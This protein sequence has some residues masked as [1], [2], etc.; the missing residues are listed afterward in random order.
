MQQT[1]EQAT[2]RYENRNRSG[3]IVI[4]GTLLVSMTFSFACYLKGLDILPQGPLFAIAEATKSAWSEGSLTPQYYHDVFESARQ[5]SLSSSNEV[6]QDVFALTDDG[7]LLPKHSIFTVLIGVPFYALF[8]KFGFWILQQLFLLVLVYSTHRQVEIVSGRSM[9]IATV[10]VTCVFTPL[11]LFSFGPVYD[12][13]GTAL[14]VAGIYVGLSRP[15]VGGFIA[16]L[17]VFVRPT[18]ILLSLPLCLIKLRIHG[19]RDIAAS[20]LGLSGAVI[21]YTA[22]NWSWWGEPFLTAYHRLPHFIAG[23]MILRR[24][25]LGFN[26]AIF[27]ADWLNKLF[28]PN[29]AFSFNVALVAAP[30]VLAT[31]LRHKERGFLLSC[32][33]L[34]LLYSLYVFSYPMWS[35]SSMY[36]NRFLL[37]AI[38]IYI[39]SL[40]VAFGMRQGRQ[41][42]PR[43]V[44]QQN[45]AL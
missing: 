19:R 2:P 7:R 14:V 22:L 40:L 38:F 36:G 39:P 42:G 17:A 41:N 30:W 8:G 18:F 29:G 25:P 15:A 5:L 43:S 4:L 26:W 9:P 10:I 34:G 20:I 27:S 44:Q 28:G 33:G 13:Q 12:L 1:A 3:A 11:L 16:G 35:S 24:T 31:L 32:C 6:Y 21:P 23:D 37:P 45:S